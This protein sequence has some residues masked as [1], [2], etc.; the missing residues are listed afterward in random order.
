MEKK[1][2]GVSVSL[3][4]SFLVYVKTCLFI[5]S[6]VFRKGYLPTSLSTIVMAPF[7]ARWNLSWMGAEFQWVSTVSFISAKLVVKPPLLIQLA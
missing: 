6:K 3:V 4:K 5:L 7:E 1:N 2:I